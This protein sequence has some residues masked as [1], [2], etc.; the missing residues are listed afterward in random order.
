MNLEELQ[1]AAAAKLRETLVRL[2]AYM[3][4]VVI[5][6]ELREIEAHLEKHIA[7]AAALTPGEEQ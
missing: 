1:N 2:R 6:N 4:T 5:T 7:V 3:D